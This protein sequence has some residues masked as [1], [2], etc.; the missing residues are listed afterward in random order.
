MLEAMQKIDRIR[1]FNDEL[2]SWFQNHKRTLPWRDLAIE[3]PTQRAYQ[4]WVSEVMLQQT[5]VSRVIAIYKAFLERFPTLRSLAEASNRDVILAWRGMGYNSRALRLRDGA[6]IILKKFHGEFPR[7]IDELRSIKGIGDY[8]AGAIRNFAFGIPTP[9]I[10]TNI[11]RIVHRFFVGSENSDG[12]W[13]KDDKYL[14]KIVEELLTN[15]L[16]GNGWNRRNRGHQNVDSSTHFFIS[17]ITSDWHA[18]LMDFG[19]LVCTKNN[20]KW[21]LFP[22]GL[23]PI[24]KAYRKVKVRTKKVIK[25]E[26]GRVIAGRF[27]PNRIF[28]GKIVEAL[29]DN[30]KGL[31]TDS[32]GTHIAVDWEAAHREWLDSLLRALVR[33][34][35]VQKKRGVYVLSA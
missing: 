28:R 26:P 29:R 7:E 25:K 16:E 20:P 2:A 35:L 22:L 8:T 5:Q 34:S 6:K 18:A 30:P 12:T 13:K 23:R 15:A 27:V 14:M 17:S 33:D 24:C 19:A 21:E 10:D 31:S 1:T 32:I 3:D 9:C 11:R 4:I